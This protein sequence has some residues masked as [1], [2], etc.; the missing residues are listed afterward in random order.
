[1]SNYKTKKVVEIDNK[2]VELGM[3]RSALLGY[4]KGTSTALQVRIEF[5]KSHNDLKKLV[6][7]DQTGILH[8][9]DYNS[10]TRDPQVSEEGEVASPNPNAC[11][12]LEDEMGQISM[13]TEELLVEFL[14]GSSPLHLVIVNSRN[15]RKIGSA[16]VKAG[17]KHVVGITK[18]S[19]AI[20]FE[21]HFYR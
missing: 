15:A 6:T 21:S 8:L 1:V 17:V 7:I 10:E 2:I 4:F 16:L 5:A 18:I 20:E 3:E 14:E 19:L 13:V 11:F 12:A 9:S